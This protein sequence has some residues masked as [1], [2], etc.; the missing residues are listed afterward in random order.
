MY[1][2][3]KHDRDVEKEVANGDKERLE[4]KLKGIY[5]F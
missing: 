2:Y 5:N 4:V 3:Y 1:N